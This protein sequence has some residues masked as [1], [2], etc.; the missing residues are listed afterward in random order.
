MYFN[1]EIKR[2]LRACVCTGVDKKKCVKFFFICV[3]FQS[4]VTHVTYVNGR[5]CSLSY[6]TASKVYLIVLSK[7]KVG[8]IFV[9]SIIVLFSYYTIYFY[10]LTYLMHRIHTLEYENST[11][12]Q[13]IHTLQIENKNLQDKLTSL[14]SSSSQ[15]SNQSSPIKFVEVWL[16]FRSFLTD[17]FW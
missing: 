14:S 12:L 6:W 10:E 11:L 17:I 13:K 8:S 1:I 16:D 15:L 5:R 7:K 9:L 2:H 3:K 4:H